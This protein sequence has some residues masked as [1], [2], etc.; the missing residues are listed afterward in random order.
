[1]FKPNINRCVV[2]IET[3]GANPH[4][5]VIS[6][7]VTILQAQTSAIDT[8]EFGININEYE[9]SADVF[10]ADQS[11]LDWW[12]EKEGSKAYEAAFSGKLS[13]VEACNALR[14]TYIQ[15]KC[16]EVW[17]NHPHFDITILDILFKHCK[18]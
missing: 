18:I 13:I 16:K 9:T 5:P 10:V 12:E 14:E 4:A 11:T 3:L 7:G 1:M 17:A 2:D 6:I 8:F 15:Y